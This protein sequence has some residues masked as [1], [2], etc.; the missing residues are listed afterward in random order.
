M[1]KLTK[2]LFTVLFLTLLS[3]S[4]MVTTGCDEEDDPDPIVGTWVLDKAEIGGQ[5]LDLAALGSMTVVF[6][7][8]S[9]TATGT[10]GGESVNDTGT[11]TR[12]GDVVTLT[13]SSDDDRITLTKEGDYYVTSMTED[14]I[15]TIKLY[16]KKR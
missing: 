4:L 2:N 1:K 14:G 6:T 9:W 7:D 16:F 8:D 11:W 10:M 3:V 13:P 15:G 12:N 5:T